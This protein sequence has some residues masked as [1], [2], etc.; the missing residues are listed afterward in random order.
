MYRKEHQDL[1]AMVGEIKGLMRNSSDNAEQIVK[2]LGSMTGKIK[3]HLASED[4][5]MYPK[6]ISSTNTEAVKVA[7]D[8]QNE[9][10]GIKDAW[11]D[12][13][14]RWKSSEKIKSDSN[15]FNNEANGLFSALA[16][17]IEKEE[18]VLYKLAEE[19]A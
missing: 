7:T 15:S 19:V 11:V 9:M 3:L 13:V 14:T 4:Q 8:F 16:N 2:T 6:L 18:S 10:G 1:V 17:R 12:F 5:N